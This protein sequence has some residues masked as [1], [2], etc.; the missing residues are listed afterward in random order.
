NRQ[1]DVAINGPGFFVVLDPTTGQNMYT[2]SGNFSVNANNQLVIGSAQTGRQL[3]PAITVPQDYINITIGPD[4]TVQVQ[5]ANS[6][7]FQIAGQ[8]QTARFFNPQGLLKMG[9]NLYSDT[10]SSGAPQI[11]TPGTI[12][13]GTLVQ[14]TLELS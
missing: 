5:Q 4:G 8:I 3:F 9:E 1:L 10:L 13:L 14:N 12:G 11:A 6:N 7:Q 2:R